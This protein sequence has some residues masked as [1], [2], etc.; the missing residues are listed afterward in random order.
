MFNQRGRGL[1]QI[2][3]LEDHP[4]E[5]KQPSY[6]KD[7]GKRYFSYVFGT[8]RPRVYDGDP[9]KK[10]IIFP[11]KVVF[12]IS[13]TD[14][15]AEFL[16]RFRLQ[17]KGPSS[18]ELQAEFFPNMRINKEKSNDDFTYYDAEFYVAPDA[19]NRILSYLPLIE[20]I[21]GERIKEAIKEC[22]SQYNVRRVN[23]KRKQK[24]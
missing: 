6:L 7:M 21:D 20:V 8:M 12:R 14:P 19:V 1:D 23:Q 9:E 16:R 22:V 5:L 15:K 3:K 24:K 18:N 4:D 2:K 10:R 17:A 11:E 13:A